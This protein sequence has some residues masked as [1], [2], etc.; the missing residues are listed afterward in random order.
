MARDRRGVSAIEFAMIAPILILIYVAI[1]EAGN[2]LT[3]HRRTS[4]VASTAADLAAQTKT[5]TND[6]LKDVIKASGALLT[7]Y[8][9][10]PLRVVVSSVVADKNNLG[11]VDWS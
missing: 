2:L 5:I 4:S 7:P 11:K 6:D 10:T 9:E 3:L 1:V 8:P